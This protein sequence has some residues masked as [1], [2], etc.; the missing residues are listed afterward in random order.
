MSEAEPLRHCPG[1]KGVA[2]LAAWL[3]AAAVVL[4]LSACGSNQVRSDA[5]P[6]S[7]GLAAS[8]SKGPQSPTESLDPWEPTNRRI[9]AFNRELDDHVMKPVARAWIRGVPKPVRQ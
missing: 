6:Q 5:A 8:Q 1:G 7:D 4:S 9:Y 2:R 3:F